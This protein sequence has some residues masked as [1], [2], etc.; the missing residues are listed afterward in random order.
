MQEKAPP[1]ADSLEP[2]I[3]ASNVSYRYRDRLALDSV[4]FSINR[5]EIFGFL[6]PNG[7][8]KT[9][10]FR[11]LSTLVTPSQGEVSI[12]GKNLSTNGASIRRK[13]GV[14]FQSPSL[15]ARLTVAENLHHHGRLYGIT[16]GPLREKTERVLARMGIQDRAN[17]IADTLSGGLKRRAELAKA[18][19]HGPEVMLLDEPS[20]GLDPGARRDFNNYLVELRQRDGA[21]IALTT[22]YLEE[23]ERCDRIAILD[24]GKLVAIAPP[25]ALKN[26]IGGEVI[27]VHASEPEKLAVRMRERL[28]VEPSLVDGALRIEARRGH[29]LVR[30]IVEQFGSEVD[31][32]TFGRPTLEDVFIRLTGHRFNSEGGPG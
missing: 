4:S 29:E 19:L 14:V 6:G 27:V 1:P 11:I 8:G 25:R 31:S 2:A 20:T 3:T 24:Q 23:A 22:H 17:D 21:T 5:G 30:Q 26:Q 15:D 28:S 18:L 12:L 10:L 9:T 32:I 7:G 16:G 13:L